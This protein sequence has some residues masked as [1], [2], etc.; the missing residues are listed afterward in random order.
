MPAPFLWLAWG[1]VALALL[2][3]PTYRWWDGARLRLRLNRWRK[4]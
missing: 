2:L 3:A 4:R 1:V